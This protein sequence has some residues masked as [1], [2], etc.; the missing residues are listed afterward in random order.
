MLFT[1]L[2][3]V[4][5]AWLLWAIFV[6]AYVSSL[7]EIKRSSW[8]FK[9]YSCWNKYPDNACQYRLI[10][11]VLPLFLA[12]ILFGAGLWYIILCPLRFI[13]NWV[14]W[15][16]LFGRAPCD[17]FNK[18]YWKDLATIDSLPIDTF[19]DSIR[20]GIGMKTFMSPSP[21][22]ILV[23]VGVIAGVFYEGYRIFSGIAGVREWYIV[24]IAASVVLLALIVI[25]ITTRPSLKIMWAMIIEKLCIDLKVVD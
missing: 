3:I 7:K 14:I 15:P 23:C 4:G 6:C 11:M 25:W 2:W 12:I 9:F 10:L 24:I 21:F 18:K 8:H 19:M 16:F 5:V 22:V 13:L 17:G 20:G 1:T